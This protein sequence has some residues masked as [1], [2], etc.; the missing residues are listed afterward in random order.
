MDAEWKDP[1]DEQELKKAWL[2]YAKK[3]EKKNPRLSSILNNHP[4][5]LHSGTLVH[6]R[7]KNK[8][9]DN[10]L[11]EQKS[12]IFPFLRRE[13]K[14]ADLELETLVVTDGQKTTRAFTASEK[15]KLMAQKN[16]ALLLLTKKF[17]LD[18]E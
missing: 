8:T 1:V 2:L 12:S 3:V 5:Q 4:P 10:E 14:N 13:L 15:A 6:V 18:I 7:L 11:Q 9:Q 16:P 17:D